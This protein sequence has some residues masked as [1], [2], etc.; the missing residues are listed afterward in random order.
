MGVLTWVSAFLDSVGPAAKVKG[1][2]ARKRR[3]EGARVGQ[4]RRFQDRRGALIPPERTCFLVGV[5]V[6]I[7]GQPGS[8]G[9]WRGGCCLAAGSFRPCGACPA[10]LPLSLG[11]SPLGLPV[12]LHW[13]CPFMPPFHTLSSVLLDLK[14]LTRP[15]LSLKVT[16][17]GRYHAAVQRLL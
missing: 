16:P 7:L 6:A 14:T 3:M 9:A 10:T 5:G 2:E 12:G 8:Y 11:S 4:V 17:S 15:S 13:G 1:G